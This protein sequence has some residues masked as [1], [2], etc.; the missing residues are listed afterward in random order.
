MVWKAEDASLGRT[1]ALKFLPESMAAAAESRRRFVR[2]ARAASRLSHPGIATVYETGEIDG[3]LYIAIEWVDGETVADLTASGPLAVADALGIARD[4]AHALGHAH[5]HG[6]LHRDLSSRNLMVRRDGHVSI[7]DFGLALPEGTS[8]ITSSS[9]TLGTIPYL[10]PEIVL[11]NASSVRSDVYALGV[12]LYEMLTATLPFRGERPEAILHGIINDPLELPSAR[13]KMI[14]SEV[15]AVMAKVLARDPAERYSSAEAFA[16]A[17]AELTTGSLRRL[18]TANPPG[19]RNA[20]ATTPTPGGA[21]PS[22]IVVL[23]FQNLDVGDT[24]DSSREIYARGI[25]ETI[26]AQLARYPGILVVSPGMEI[27]EGHTRDV[28][29]LARSCGADFVLRGNIQ[30]S[31]S[32]L[33]ISF[34]L[35]DPIQSMQIAGDVLDGALTEV[36]L[37]QDQ[38]ARRVAGA[39][40]P[41]AASIT[42]L[43]LRTGLEAVA[44]QERFLQAIGYLRRP[45]KEAQVDGAISILTEL[46]DGNND[47]ALVEAALGRASLYK[48]QFTHDPLWA[49]RAD[50]ACARAL[51]MD[52]R[53]ADVHL[54]LGNTQRLIGR[55]AD[56]VRSFRRALKLRPDHPEALLGLAS[57][58]EA[59]GQLPESEEIHQ[60]LLLLRPDFWEASHRLAIFYFNRG[61]YQD[62]V[63]LW[64]RVVELTPDNARAWYDLGGAYFR[65]ER[66]EDAISAYD[67]AIAIQPEASA[68][69][70]LGT[71]HYFLGHWFEAAAMFEKAVAKRPNF[72]RHWGNLGDAY[73]WIPGRQSDAIAAYD[74]A[75]ALMRAELEVNP[76]NAQST[77]WLAEWLARRDDSRGAIQTLRRALKLAPDDVN[78]MARA[79]NVFHL[80][81]DRAEALHWIEKSLLA[82]YG[83]SEFERDPDLKPLREDVAYARLVQQFTGARSG[84]PQGSPDEGEP[85][86]NTERGVSA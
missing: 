62:S 13:R 46:R 53:S 43:P 17:I 76:K 68:Y 24:P 82:G 54:T 61:R 14:S 21:A 59:A 22:Y 47:S 51:E 75:I 85:G 52:P 60:R 78:L 5:A 42:G 69:S 18:P 44:V 25:T 49:T 64:R 67:H 39:L 79:V 29:E 71:L 80:A 16:V 36:F 73:R 63:R 57:A 26:G 81:G 72:P 1:V 11:G 37:L 9:S 23:P 56:S 6:V 2:E 35:I 74:H 33:R 19:H 34:A 65:L 3:H 30:R 27:T 77:G 31:G 12:V 32:R 58:L 15:D 83:L 86:R 55:L 40:R 8:R 48:Y 84:P 10:A 38:L 45:D 41:G 50:E 28:R 70:N 7:V 20:A 4:A 66:F